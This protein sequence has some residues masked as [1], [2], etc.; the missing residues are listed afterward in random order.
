VS[1]TQFAP[2]HLWK[3]DIN[4]YSSLHEIG[5]GSSI[6]SEKKSEPAAGED[7]PLARPGLVRCGEP[8]S[9]AL[10]GACLFL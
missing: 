1:H 7:G 4:C 5:E 6:V 8:A 10:G 9:F 3:V 2:V